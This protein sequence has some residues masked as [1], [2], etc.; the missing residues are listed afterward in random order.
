MIVYEILK[1]ETFSCCL[2]MMNDIDNLTLIVEAV[3][4]ESLSIIYIKV[5]NVYKLSYIY[6]IM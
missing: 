3:L 5:I 4:V 6:I 1:A 2:M